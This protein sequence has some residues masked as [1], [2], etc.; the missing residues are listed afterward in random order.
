MMEFSGTTLPMSSSELAPPSYSSVV[1]MADENKVVVEEEEEEE[2][3]GKKKAIRREN[4]LIAVAFILT[5]VG[6][7][8]SAFIFGTDRPSAKERLNPQENERVQPYW[9]DLW[10]KDYCHAYGT[11]EYSSQL[12]NIAPGQD[13]VGACKVTPITIHGRVLAAPTSCEDK[14]QDGV[15]GHWIVDFGETGCQ[16]YW[17]KLYDKGCVAEGSGLHRMEARL[18]NIR[19]GEDWQLMCDTAPNIVHGISFKNPISCENRGAF[20]GVV[21]I[22]EYPDNEC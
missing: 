11:R 3:E 4:Y 21:G 16:P 12:W 17:D 5:I 8:Y 14:G 7:W 18:R 9:G 15:I 2:E 6:I 19:S 13:R 1:G 10:R 20:F 22:W